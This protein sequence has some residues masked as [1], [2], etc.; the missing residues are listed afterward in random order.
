MDAANGKNSILR[1]KRVLLNDKDNIPNG[2]MRVL[3]SDVSKV[4]SSYF[5]YSPETLK[6]DVDLDANGRYCIHIEA[7]AERV[8]T[9]KIV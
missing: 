6:I 2:L 3:R 8:K 4:L 9:V 1:L 7:I 5:D